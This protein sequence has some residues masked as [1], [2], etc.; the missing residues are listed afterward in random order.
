M[1]E[2]PNET[3]RTSPYQPYI[4]AAHKGR[5]AAFYRM[6]G[7]A[8]RGLSA[9]GRFLVSPLLR[10]THRLDR[11]RRL[12]AAKRELHAM[13]D[14]L[15]F[16]MGISREEIDHVVRN[17]KPTPDVRVDTSVHPHEAKR[18][19]D[20]VDLRKERDLMGALITH[21]PW[22]RYSDRRRDDAA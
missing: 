9:L 7:L 10:A 18:A 21:G 11:T 4:R 5:S 15:L 16:D 12:Q 13:D 22:G 2:Y 20:V 17:G 14:R 8:G 6:L 19:A 1:M 3:R